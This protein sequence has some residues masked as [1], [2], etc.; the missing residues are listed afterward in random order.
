M[1]IL[2][3][4]LLLFSIC[5]GCKASSNSSVES[6]DSKI[7]SGILDLRAAN[8][9]SS[10]LL[11]NGSWEFY[12]KQLIP[13]FYRNPIPAEYFPM[14]GFW[15]EKSV[16]QQTLDS[17]GYASYRLKL[18]LPE[19]RSLYA[20]SVI[21]LESAYTLYVNGKIVGKN[22]IVGTSREK[23]LPEWRPAV[24]PFETSGETEL[25]LHVSNFHH[26]LGGVWQGLSFG[27]ADSLL[28][29]QRNSIALELFV[30]GSIFMIGVYHC[31]IF[32]V[33]RRELTFLQLGLFC[34][35]MAVRSLVTGQR[36][37][38][39]LVP[40]LSWESLVRLDYLTVYVGAPVLHWYL[41]TLFK[42]YYNR[43]VFGVFASISGFFSALV[44]FSDP[45][46]FT[47]FAS[48]YHLV[49]FSCSIYFLY[50]N[51]IAI[52]RKETGA[53]V[54]WLGWIAS[55]LANLNDVLYT[56]SIIRSGYFSAIGLHIF[57]L[58]HSYYLAVRYANT[59]NLSERLALRM[60]SLLMITRNLNRS[61]SR[62]TAIWTA[63]SGILEAFNIKS[64]YCV[65]LSQP[66]SEK[67]IRL[68]PDSNSLPE[69]ALSDFNEELGSLSE[70]ELLGT[71][72]RL[73]VLRGNE[74]LCVLE[75]EG[76][77]VQDLEREKLYITGV[78]ESLGVVL[79]NIDKIRAEALATVGQAA[80]EIVH[81]INHHC[82]V[83]GIQVRTALQ[84]PESAG[85]I[86]EQIEREAAYM[87]NMALDILDFARERIIVRLET[88][89]LSE[90]AKRIETDL[91]DQLKDIPIE[92]KVVLREQG[93][94]RMDVD[95][96]R[97]VVL[98][99]TRNAA[100]AMQSG[101]S[102]QVVIDREDNRLYFIFQDN[103]PGIKPELRSKLFQPF[104]LIGG[105]Q[106]GSGL[107]L[108][109]VRRIVLAHG[110]EI[111]F[112]SELGKGS[113]FTI[114]LPSHV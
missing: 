26:R 51:F 34:F 88:H 49:L 37:I 27:K 64:G 22:G 101:G 58:T 3:I 32:F 54:L 47:K 97:R 82:Q 59:F 40:D 31:L 35:I 91:S 70:L 77:K 108:A 89:A 92:Y 96:F 15:N 104:G 57:L 8:P 76:I 74:I 79:E 16:G 19:E 39:Q 33:R 9:E 4:F 61:N 75:C 17:S 52:L 10:P 110:G 7:E 69:A 20:I 67:F 50:I 109:V 56:S 1:R 41:F 102:F 24:Y 14:P 72:L 99:L 36:Y 13:S 11:L 38:L 18:I 93:F 73:P 23:E 84:E 62:E 30:A 107:G 85:V 68:L 66:D 2:Y 100:A 44:L 90:I 83:I 63:F 114:E 112:H 53:A 65:F 28:S 71:R 98:N 21:D 87:R 105:D 5:V 78:C 43:Y 48:I 86:L 103:G 111:H 113:R 42:K 46:I 106:K 95:R 55:T 6:K 12:W 29:D 94:V 81:D 45:L 80:S 60:E 25:L